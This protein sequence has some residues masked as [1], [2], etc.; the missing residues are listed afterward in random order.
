[1]DIYL[2]ECGYDNDTRP[3]QIS[4]HMPPPIIHIPPLKH[5]RVLA[6]Y[7]LTMALQATHRGK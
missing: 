6:A 5:W 7:D 4:I 2:D 3:P 1:M